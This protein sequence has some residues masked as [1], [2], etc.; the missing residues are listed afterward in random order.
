MIIGTPTVF[1]DPATGRTYNQAIAYIGRR[2]VEG[3]GRDDDIRHTDYRVVA[4]VRGDPLRG[5]SYDLYGQ[6]GRTIRNE[7]YKNDFSVRRLRQALD[8]VA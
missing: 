1:T 4:G 2:N 5:I 6:F 7:S 3:G 8:V